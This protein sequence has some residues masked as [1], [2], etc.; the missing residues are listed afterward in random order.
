MQAI[1]E[2]VSGEG[3]R[4]EARAR[5]RHR[6]TSGVR[7]GGED[8]GGWRGARRRRAG[9]PF[10]RPA[11]RPP[12]LRQHLRKK[13]LGPLFARIHQYFLRGALLYY[14]PTVYERELSAA[15][16]AKP[17]S[18][19]TTTMVMPSGPALHDVEHLA[20][21]LRVQRRGGLVEEHQLGLHGQGLA[22]AL[23]AAGRPRAAPGRRPASPS[24]PLRTG[25]P[26][27]PPPPAS[28]VLLH[29]DGRLH[30]VLD[31][32]QMREEVE[33]PEDHADLRPLAGDFTGLIMQHVAPLRNRSVPSTHRRPASIL[34]VVDA[35]QQGG[36]PTAGGPERT[37]VSRG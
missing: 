15:S 35:A 36:L 13:E 16:F 23:A 29:P 34:Q 27:P 25:A 17:I 22:L 4:E 37:K 1:D 9:R 33:T 18:W 11:R 24:A 10:G 12:Y 2:T 6:Q 3:A 5:R 32:G 7:T 31:G 30:H 26:P 19:V 14:D 21:Q 8:G 28:R 20:H